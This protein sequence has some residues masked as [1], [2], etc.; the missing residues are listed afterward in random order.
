MSD[1]KIIPLEDVLSKFKTHNDAFIDNLNREEDIENLGSV[2][3]IQ[4]NIENDI[5]GLKVSTEFKKVSFI[6]EIKNGLGEEVKKNPNKIKKI[7]QPKPKWH[8]RMSNYIKNIFT[9]F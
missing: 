6:N 2:K 7:E 9:K 1:K 3:S 4:E 5:K 8:V